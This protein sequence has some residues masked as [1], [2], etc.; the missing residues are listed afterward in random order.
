MKI[1]GIV[2]EF[3]ENSL[4]YETYVSLRESVEWNNFSE[5]QARKALEK[6][7]YSLVV[8]DETKPIAMARIVGDGII[9]TIADV[10]VSPQYQGK[11]I[12]KAMI[13]K[14][15]Q[16]VEE[17]TPPGSRVSL[18]LLAVNGKEAFYEKLGFKILPH[19]FCGPGMR[20]VMYT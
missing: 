14:L 18:Q 10:V 11:G 6:C 8:V 15:I 13:E 20:K 16:H 4:D 2:M 7:L 3:K 9:I 5:V 19:E 1:G 17:T 12:G